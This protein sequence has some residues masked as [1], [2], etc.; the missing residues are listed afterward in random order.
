MRAVNVVDELLG[1]DGG[2]VSCASW[3]EVGEL[4]ES[5]DDDED[6]GVWRVFGGGRARGWG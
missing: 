5:A 1:E 4:G 2:V 6:S 3:N